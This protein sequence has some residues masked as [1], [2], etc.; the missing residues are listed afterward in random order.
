MTKTRNVGKIFKV[1]ELGDRVHMKLDCCCFT[2]PGKQKDIGSS[3]NVK[4]DYHEML[5]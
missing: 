5:N 4:E 1:T 2:N 3:R